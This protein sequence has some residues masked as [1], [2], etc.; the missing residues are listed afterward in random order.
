MAS[1]MTSSWILAEFLQ[2]CRLPP[3]TRYILRMCRQLRFTWDMS[4]P[5]FSVFSG[6]EK[7]FLRTVPSNCAIRWN[8]RWAWAQLTKSAGDFRQAVRPSATQDVDVGERESKGM[9]KEGIVVAP[10]G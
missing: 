1:R 4:H 7:I 5:R 8:S 6:A 2:C 3:A 9:R 10:N